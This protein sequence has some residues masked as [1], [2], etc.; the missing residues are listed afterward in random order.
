MDQYAAILGA[1]RFWAI[2]LEGIDGSDFSG[3]SVSGA[4]DVNGDGFDDLIVGAYR[5]DPNGDY[6][7]GESYVVFPFERN[8]IEKCNR[9]RKKWRNYAIP[10]RGQIP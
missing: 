6:S 4:G 8:S 2:R 1:H 3:I 5:A 7:A 10:Y 9:K